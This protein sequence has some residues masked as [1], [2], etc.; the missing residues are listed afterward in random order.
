MNITNDAQLK[1]A[2]L[3]ELKIAL[4]KAS[5]KIQLQLWDSIFSKI[6]SKPE[7]EFYDR[8]REFLDSVIKPEVKTNGF[9]VEVTLGMDSSKMTPTQNDDRFFN[10]HMD[11]YGNEEWHGETIPES[12]LSWWDTGTTNSKLPSLPQTDYWFDI[13]GDRGYKDNPDYQKAIDII[14]ETVEKELSKIGIIRRI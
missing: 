7:S 1:A 3:K 10:A 9:S 8:T 13:M 4:D 11:I 14:E 12:L 5:A 2:I 6:Y